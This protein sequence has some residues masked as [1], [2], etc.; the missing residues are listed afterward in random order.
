[1][2]PRHSRHELYSVNLASFTA[3]AVTLNVSMLALQ[4]LP[5]SVSV[6]VTPKVA[7]VK[8]AA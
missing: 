6:T 8:A 7:F 3:A 4:E 2:V 5:P 1:M